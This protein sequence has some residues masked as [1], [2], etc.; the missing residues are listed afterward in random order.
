M[1]AVAERHRA[2]VPPAALA[3]TGP[4]VVL[5]PWRP[6]VLARFEEVWRYRRLLPYLAWQFVLRRYRR[7]YL[8]WFWIPLKPGIDILSKTLF[9]GGLLSVGSGDRPY[10]IFVAFS[11]AGWI[12]FERCLYWGARSGQMAKS[13]A[14]GRHFPR[15]P[16]VVASIGPSLIEY[17]LYT[18]VAIG[19]VLYYL[20]KGHYY[21]APPTHMVFAVCAFVMLLAFGLSVGLILAPLT[22]ITK[23]IR[24]LLQYV[25]QLWY[26]VTPIVYPISSIPPKYQ[27][28]A[29]LNPITAPLEL[30]K[31]GLLDTAPP[32]A[33]SLLASVVAL[34]VFLVTGL[35]FSSRMEGKA[36]ARL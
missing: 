31:Y 7:T 4:V 29:E 17:V 19:G 32:K 11:S 5:R 36:V 33:T 35:A 10:F 30:M 12:L 13:F 22:E 6:G 16:V 21:L 27:A 34:P 26:F 2:A 1:S 24:Y 3:E 8:S 25:L 20:F 18:I 23:E 14:R 9:F 28:V 15:T